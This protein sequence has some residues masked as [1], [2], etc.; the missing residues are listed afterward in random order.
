MSKFILLLVA[1]SKRLSLRRPFYY[2]GLR[3]DKYSEGP[4]HFGQVVVAVLDLRDNFRGRE[5]LHG[6][7]Q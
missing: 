4:I 1:G 6:I 3:I 7:C 5:M 2:A